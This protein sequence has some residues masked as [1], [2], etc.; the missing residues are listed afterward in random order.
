MNVENMSLSCIALHRKMIG[1]EAERVLH[2]EAVNLD[3]DPDYL[4]RFSV[5]FG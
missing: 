4:E 2:V 1:Q 5:N 3:V